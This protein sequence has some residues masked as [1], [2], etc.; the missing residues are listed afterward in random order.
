MTQPAIGPSE[1][2]GALARDP[3]GVTFVLDPAGVTFTLDLEDERERRAGP[4]RYR[5]ATE[6]LLAWLD[7]RGIRATVFIVGELTRTAPDLLRAVAEAGHEI[8]CHS[9]DHTPIPQQDRAAFA[10]ATRRAKGELEDLT[11]RAVRGYRAPVFSLTPAVPWAPEVLVG[12]GLAYSSSVLPARNPLHGWPGAPRQPFRWPAGLLEIPAPVL[13]LGALTLP[14]LGGIYLRY[15]PARL[16]L[17]AARRA[18]DQARWL[19]CHPYDFDAGAPYARLRGAS[20]LT[21]G[22]LWLNR[23]RTY[24]KLAALVAGGLR[25]APPFDDRIAAGAFA[26]VPE[27]SPPQT[28]TL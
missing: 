9:L 10:E 11:G 26:R 7:A 14:F 4:P 8:A 13:S 19:Y 18:D 3:A 27:W 17:Q 15:L 5:A 28:T 2:A 25:F 21:S 22:L 6:R 20:H 12:L 24:D 16:I 1:S 23:V